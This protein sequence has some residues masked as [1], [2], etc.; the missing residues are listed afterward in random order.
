[1]SDEAGQAKWARRIAGA[2]RDAEQ[3][4]LGESV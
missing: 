4:L 3:V 2:L 1:V